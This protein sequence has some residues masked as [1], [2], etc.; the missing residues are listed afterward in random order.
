M[1]FIKKIYYQKYS[2]KSYSISNVDLIIDRLFRNNKKGIYLDIGCNH[3]IKHN[4]TYLLYERG[5]N[6]INIDLDKTSIDE[7]KKL[8]PKDINIQIGV[9]NYAGNKKVF[10]YH[11]RSPLNTLSKKLK[12][13]RTKK[14]TKTFNLQV[15]TL[16]N[17]IKKSKFK[18]KQINLMSIDI[19]NHEYEALQNF[20]FK[21]Y[22]I[23]LIVTEFTNLSGKK[24]ETYNLSIS[25]IFK[26]KIYK[27]LIKNNYKLINWVNSDLIFANKNSKILNDYY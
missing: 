9:S 15:D 14:P 8:R 10:Y 11:K 20:N 18:N 1:N 24:I 5:W 25:D 6:G 13:F 19:E 2:K 17:I 12:E 22:K 21:K 23:D 27:L 7:F 4:N 3:P 26:S 16:N